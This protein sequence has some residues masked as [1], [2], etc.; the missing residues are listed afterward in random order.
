MLK[1]KIY[2]IIRDD[3]DDS[4]SISNFFNKFIVFLIIINVLFVVA[5][6][7]NLPKSISQKIQACEFIIGIIFSVEYLLRLWT[8]DLKLKRF[9]PL[10]ARIRHATS[11]M[12]LVDL[13][14]LLPI[15]LPL[16]FP[17]NLM[18]LRT[19]RI[20]RLFHLFKVNR[21]TG[22][23]SRLGKVFQN[24]RVELLSSFFVLCIL[25]LISSVAIYNFENPAQPQ[26][27][28]NALSGLWWAITTVT[29]VGYG[30]MVPITLMGRLFA[31]IMS[32]LGV[33]LV[34][35]PTGII[36]SGFMEVDSGEQRSRQ[37]SFC[38]YCGEKIE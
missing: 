35:V 26:V 7:F 17:A 23:I 6:T 27:F 2:E 22:A 19:L 12:S 37:K 20:F 1:K 25:I 36:A 33:A 24:K 18:I 13:L 3:N 21:Y 14:A 8:A 34:A 9:S 38:P 30:D 4:H 15:Y 32:L 16:V 11:F 29:T 10:K 5:D 31:G 28:K